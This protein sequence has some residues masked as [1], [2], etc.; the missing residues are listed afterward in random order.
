[1]KKTLNRIP[2]FR[3]PIDAAIFFEKNN[4]LDFY[5]EDEFKIVNPKTDRRFSYKKES[6]KKLIS[7]RIDNEIL[8]NAKALST[9]LKR[10]YQQILNEW[11][12]RG[13]KKA[14]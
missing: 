11:L 3:S 6:R 7:I 14:S 5:D 9:K 4:I 2:K 8:N 1:M 10:P 12:W 13:L